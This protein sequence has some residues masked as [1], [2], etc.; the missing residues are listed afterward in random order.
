LAKDL[1]REYP[2]ERG[3]WS[4]RL[5]GLRQEL[6]GDLTG[7]TQRA[8]MTLTAAVGFLLFIC[9]GN[10]ASLLLAR[11]VTREREMALRRAL[12]AGL[13]RVVRQLL[14]ES[15]VLAVLGGCAGLLLAYSSVPLLRSLN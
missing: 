10:V 1:E 5:I 4:V 14:T 11:G 8:L 3:G 9:C 12:G 2:R 6:I 13:G 7:R 15:T